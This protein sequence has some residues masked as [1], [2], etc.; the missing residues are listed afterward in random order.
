MDNVHWTYGGF[1][2]EAM[3]S[4]FIDPNSNNISKITSYRYHNLSLP[5]TKE[6]SLPNL[7]FVGNFNPIEGH[8]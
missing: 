4:F 3:F 2:I 5:S 1:D 6:N 7:A 8:F